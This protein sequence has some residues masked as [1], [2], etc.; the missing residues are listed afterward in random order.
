MTRV[1]LGELIL[2]VKDKSG[3]S[4]R[5]MAERAS[6]H[7]FPLSYARIQQLAE[8]PLKSVPQQDTLLALSHALGVSVED[9]AQAATASLLREMGVAMSPDLVNDQRARAFVTITQGLDDDSLGHVLR[10][11]ER[12]VEALESAGQ[13]QTSEPEG[14]PRDERKATGTTG[15]GPE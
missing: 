14:A 10:V 7:G 2:T 9:V 15:D 13:G 3:D 5:K 11:T 12:L 8:N 6:A 1:T 4:Y